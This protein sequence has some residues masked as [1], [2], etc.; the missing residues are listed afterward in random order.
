[1]YTISQYGTMI[2]LR[3][4]REPIDDFDMKFVCVVVILT[5]IAI[6]AMLFSKR[7][8]SKYYDSSLIFHISQGRLHPD[9]FDIV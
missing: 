6:N 7:E 8:S 3:H 4:C 2:C 1:M 5:H 9:K